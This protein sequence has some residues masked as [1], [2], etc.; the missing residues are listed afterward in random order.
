MIGHTEARAQRERERAKNYAENGVF[1]SPN[2]MIK[3]GDPSSGSRSGDDARVV[4]VERRSLQVA[5]QSAQPPISGRRRRVWTV[6]S[7]HFSGFCLTCQLPL[8]NYAGTAT[9]SVFGLIYDRLSIDSVGGGLILRKQMALTCPNMGP[10]N[11][12]F[13]TTNEEISDVDVILV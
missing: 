9:A 11:N 1:G 3:D 5:D 4:G 2:N 12:L 6:T 13:G 10:V 7:V 8:L